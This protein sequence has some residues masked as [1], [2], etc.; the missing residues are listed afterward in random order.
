MP[1]LD[2]AGGAPPLSGHHHDSDWASAT[3]QSAEQNHLIHRRESAQSEK[4]LSTILHHTPLTGKTKAVC[5]RDAQKRERVRRKCQVAFHD[6]HLS[7]LYMNTNSWRR[8]RRSQTEISLSSLHVA[9][10]KSGMKSKASRP[11]DVLSLLLVALQ[12]DKVKHTRTHTDTHKNTYIRKSDFIS[13]HHNRPRETAR[14]VGEWNFGPTSFTYFTQ[15]QRVQ[16][17]EAFLIRLKGRLKI[18]TK[19]PTK[20]NGSD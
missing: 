14:L 10:N 3:A 12:G 13:Q 6:T 20:K 16:S 17:G 18:A 9:L 4:I 1:R 2:G 19:K 15:L 7:Q 11:Q 8:S 5:S